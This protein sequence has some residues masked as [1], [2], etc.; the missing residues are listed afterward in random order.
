MQ[1]NLMKNN[2]INSEEFQEFLKY[3]KAMFEYEKRADTLSNSNT[4]TEERGYLV[5]YDDFMEL[6][7]MLNYDLNKFYLKRNKESSIYSSF[8]FEQIKKL[9]PIEIK[10]VAYIKDIIINIKCVLVTKELFDLIINKSKNA[11]S[12]LVDKEYLTL[13]LKY[14][15][16]LEL[17]HNKLILDNIDFDLNEPVSEIN[18]IYNSMLKYFIYDNNMINELNKSIKKSGHGNLVTKKWIDEWKKYTNYEFIKNKYFFEN[19]NIEKNKNSIYKEI[20][21]FKEKYKYTI[22]EADIIIIKNKTELTSILQQESLGF[23]DSEFINKSPYFKRKADYN[24]SVNYYM[25]NGILEIFKGKDTISF[26]CNDNIIYFD[27]IIGKEDEANDDLKQ[28]IKI[29]FF[30]KYLLEDN[31]K[32]NKRNIIIK[33][34]ILIFQLN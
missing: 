4:I 8:K 26:K 17:K 33:D 22:S 3:N 28:L 11:I 24:T 34:I 5:Y 20:I 30:Q 6:K 29:Y 21:N 31:N 9:E 10:S 2:D 32:Y 14:Q 12:F 1:K 23:V 25:S 19:S 16:K 13:N 27:N 15:E 7:K 18:I